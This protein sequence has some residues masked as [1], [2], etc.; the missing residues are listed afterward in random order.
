M[1]LVTGGAFQG[2]LKFVKKEYNIADEMISDGRDCKLDN[3]LNDLK[4]IKAINHFNLL[5][6]RLMKKEFSDKEYNNL[7][8]WIKNNEN[9]E[10]IIITDEIGNGLVPIDK[11]E[12]EY[13]ELVGRI[14]CEIAKHSNEVYRV[15]C[16]IPTKIK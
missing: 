8:D 6:K 10:L 9:K 5:V 14:C 13:R 15:Y 4:N 11:F 12:R 2:K 1:I 16:G 7:I 3:G